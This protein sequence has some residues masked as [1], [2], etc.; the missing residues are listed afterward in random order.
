MVDVLHSIFFLLNYKTKFNSD[1][2]KKL[3]GISQSNSKTF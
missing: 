1:M 3:N 2:K